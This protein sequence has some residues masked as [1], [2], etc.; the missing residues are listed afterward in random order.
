MMRSLPRKR[1]EYFIG[2]WLVVGVVALVYASIVLAI[3]D[4]DPLSFVQLGT[5]FSEGD[6]HG[7]EGYDGQFAYQ[8]ALNPAGAAPYLDVPAYRYQR[9]LYSLLARALALGR[10]A[11]IPWTLILI[12]WLALVA[13][14]R[15]TEILLQHYQASRWYA[16]P[17]GLYAGQLFS[18]RLDVS[19]PLSQCLVMLGILWGERK[20]WPLAALAFALAGLAK[21]TALLFAAGYVLYLALKRAWRDAVSVGVISAG[22]CIA[23]QVVL[24]RW[25]GQWGLGSGGAGATGFEWIPF[26]GIWRI[27]HYGWEVFALWLVILGPL[28][29]APL[30][31]ATIASIR[32]LM[33]RPLHPFP[34]VLLINSLALIVLPF[35]TWREMLAILRLSIG[36]VASVLLWGAWC[37]SRRALVYAQFWIATLAF[38]LKE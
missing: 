10:P 12:N 17:Y 19:E 7:T 35:S 11:L 3:H 30:I 2:P 4:M 21:E 37:R 16:L 15:L 25:L 29:V 33:R 36:F 34:L 26:G 14:T 32:T 24:K 13:G 23:W 8:I 31:V 5:R 27:A 1:W 18:L 38:L 6:P 20:R 9:I 28:L 22:P